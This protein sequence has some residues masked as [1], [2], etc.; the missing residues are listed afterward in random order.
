[1]NPQDFNWTE[2][3]Q[4]TVTNPTAEAYK[5]MVHNKN[6]ELPAGATAKMPGYI[7]WLYVYGL[8][9]QLAQSEGNFNRW[10]EEGY[11]QEYYDRL[12]V[13]VDKLVQEIEVQPQLIQQI[14][15][16]QAPVE[17]EVVE[18]LPAGAAPAPGQGGSY[19]PTIKPLQAKKH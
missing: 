4:V 15:G 17:A 10:N 11:R 12:V 3:Q 18:K 5:F 13:G 9:T 19:K 8:S 2:D 14:D 1:M 6:Y 7:A 16:P